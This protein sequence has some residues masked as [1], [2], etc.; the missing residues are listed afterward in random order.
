RRSTRTGREL[1][2]GIFTTHGSS[3]SKTCPWMMIRPVPTVTW[4]DDALAVTDTSSPTPRTLPLLNTSMI[5]GTSDENIWPIWNT[6]SPKPIFR[7]APDTSALTS[8]GPGES[9]IS[10]VADPSDPVCVGLVVP[11]E[12]GSPDGVRIDTSAPAI[13]LPS[14]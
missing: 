10:Q 14:G 4:L 6:E 11:P 8:I 3:I 7:S 9:S 5:L 13:G 1:F 12:I 2:S